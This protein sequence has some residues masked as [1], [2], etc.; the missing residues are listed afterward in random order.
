MCAT[1]F[2]ASPGKVSN[3]N[4]PFDVSTTITG[5]RASCA[6]A[7]LAAQMR[8]AQTPLTR[9]L[10]RM[11]HADARAVRPNRAGATARRERPAHVL[12]PRHEV[13]VDVRPPARARRPIKRLLGFVRRLG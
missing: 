8:A 5:P 7:A 11:R 12:A 3:S 6:P 2:G 4:V 9:T 13:Q 1:V 10:A